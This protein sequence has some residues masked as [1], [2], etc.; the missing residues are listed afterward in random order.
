ALPKDDENDD[1]DE[2]AAASDEPSAGRASPARSLW[3]SEE[4]DD[5]VSV[6]SVE[7][8]ESGEE[9]ELDR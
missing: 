6:G 2:G 5:Q 8:A 7:V 4:T 1:T 3:A 9:S